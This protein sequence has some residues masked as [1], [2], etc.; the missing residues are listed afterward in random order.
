M[1]AARSG[2]G[3]A[4]RERVWIKG[5]VLLLLVFAAALIARVPVPA[6]FVISIAHLG[7]LAG[8]GLLLFTRL[9]DQ[10]AGFAMRSDRDL[11]CGG[12]AMLGPA[13]FAHLACGEC[14]ASALFLWRPREFASL[15]TSE[16]ERHGWSIP[17]SVYLLA[18]LY[19]LVSVAL[20]FRYFSA[21]SI[22]R[23]FFID[24]VQ[25][26]GVTYALA[27]RIPPANP[28]FT[29]A[30]LSYYW[31]ALFPA[32]VEFRFAHRDIFD[33]WKC[34][35]L[36][37]ALLLPIALWGVVRQ[38]FARP[39]VAWA[40]LLFT[41]VFCSYEIFA[42]PDFGGALKQLVIDRSWSAFVAHMPL[43]DPDMLRGIVTPYSDQLLLE[44]FLY[45]PQNAVALM[46][47]L[48]G[49]WL[50]DTQ[51]DL[52]AA[53]CLSTLAGVNTF[54]ALPVFG[55]FALVSWQRDGL[56]HALATS[57]LV[58]AWAITWLVLCRILAWP[59]LPWAAGSSIA[60][61]LLAA[62]LT[63]QEPP[64]RR[65]GL[66][67][68]IATLLFLAG[69]LSICLLRPSANLGVLALN[70]GPA[71]VLGLGLCV[72]LALRGGVNLPARSADLLCFLL[73]AGAI[74]FALSFFLYLQ[75][76]EWI[77][78]SAR[79]FSRAVGLELNLFN[80][81][82]KV[83]KLVRLSW[84]IFAGVLLALY[85]PQVRSWLASRPLRWA[86]V[87][88][89]GLSAVTGLLRPLTYL[90]AGPVAE[91]EAGRWLDPH[92]GE[93]VILLEDFR[94]S[95]INQLLPARVFYFSMWSGGNP[96]LTHAV[97]TWVEQYL[98]RTWRAQAPRRESGIRNSLRPRRQQ[99]GA[100]SSS[101]STASDSS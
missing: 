6:V 84:T 53:F 92:R 29:G 67:L 79:A 59:P 89:L 25:R 76:V 49:L 50:W 97:G 33:V 85:L 15:A 21:D 98:P 66:W 26:L 42:L 60:M 64:P 9:Q 19:A 40:A 70:Y 47:V 56:R 20:P 83:G 52:A 54:Y 73:L 91:G 77:P 96:A 45:V 100:A 27:E 62:C 23:E 86:I 94:G 61:T 74:Y 41:F 58:V 17:I 22:S 16:D 10:P 11:V 69:L 34:G 101:R 2:I 88:L 28:F 65:C 18:L 30:P 48:V 95:M 72:H 82:H 36:W 37:N 14:G 13:D 43:G 32:A 81:Y 8:D 7:T 31:F 68:R 57:M 71:F 3:R 46:I 99:S 75:F 39:I 4:L 90:R 38:L 78:A 87:V 80:F 1:A 5:S 63:K 24:G 12:L 35:N 44:D 55:A 51:R 93:N